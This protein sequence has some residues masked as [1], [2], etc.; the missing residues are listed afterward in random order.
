MDLRKTISRRALLTRTAPTLAGGIATISA[1]VL[2][3][4]QGK[5]A[6]KSS[7]PSA[8]DKIWSCE[9]WAKKDDLALYIFR[10]RL[11]TPQPGETPKPILFLSHGSSV[12]SRPSFDLTVPGHGDYSLMDK[13]AEYGFDV[14]TMDF[15]GYGRSGIGPGNSDIASGVED[16]KAASEVILR[17]TRQTRFHLYGESSGAL[18]VG[19]FAMAAPEHVDRLVLGSFTWTGQ[20]SPTLSK[21][22]ESLDYYRTHNRRSRDRE[23]IH[24]IFTRDKPGTSDPAVAEAMADAELKFGDTVPTGTYLDM[25]TR[26]PIVDPS[27]VRSPV[28]IARGE[29]D[30]IATEEDLLNF[31][32]KLPVPDREFVILPGASHSIGLGLNRY[33]F[34]HV[35]RSFLEMPK[36]LDASSTLN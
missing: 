24:S 33:Q 35:M 17:E 19:A 10:K 6:P 2:V 1:S 9:Y 23:M 14:W 7:N 22:S 12:S 28:L 21:R 20:G 13:F 29:Y 34:W 25:T 3:F 36:R 8:Q 4:A 30:G 18:R 16:I 11:G 15:E 5:S 32:Q 27:K 31:F 26:L